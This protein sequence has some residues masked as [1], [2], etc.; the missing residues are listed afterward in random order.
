[1]SRS[2]V[3]RL[4]ALLLVAVLGVYYIVFDALGVH[5]W[6]RPYTVSVMLPSAGGIYTDA[7]V[8]YRGVEVGKVSALHLGRTDVRVDLAIDH[9]IKI[10]TDVK[11]SV[12]ELTAAAE[13]YMDL[14]PTSAT[15]PQTAPPAGVGFLHSGAT[16]TNTSTPVSVGTL[17]DTVNSLADSLH[18]QD[19][20]TVTAALAN[21]LNQAGPDLRAIINDGQT[22]IQALN[23]AV[24][25]TVTLINSGNQVLNTFNQTGPDFN[26]LAAGLDRLSGTVA[27][28]NGNVSALLSNGAVATGGFAQLL[29]ADNVP[30]AGVINGFSDTAGL[31]NARQGAVQ[32]FFQIL[33]VVSRD[34][35]LTVNSST[36]QARFQVTLNTNNTVCP[37]T[38]Q[39]AEPTSLVATADLTRNCGTSAPDLLQRG[40]A[41]APTPSGG[42]P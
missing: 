14:V 16:I 7:A 4:I 29:A 8:T 10:P 25:S 23:Q 41:T 18:P 19:L 34:A 17:L 27:A 39:M 12:R 35:A 40:A 3:S 1:V 32:A 42:T 6:N 21:G 31:A 15:G 24:P 5:L 36:G 13:Q 20:N 33:P 26:T 30:F 22:L 38:S 28:A 11:A 9:G 2:V 37:Y